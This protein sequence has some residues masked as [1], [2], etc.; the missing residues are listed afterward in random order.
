M[1]ILATWVCIDT[2]DNAS[3]FPSAKGLSSDKKIQDIYWKCLVDCLYTARVYNPDIRLAVFSNIT[4]LPAIEN[5]DLNAVFK[6]LNI[7]F[8][9][10]PFKYQTPK[11][12]YGNWRNQFYEFSIFEYI[13]NN[14]SFKPE[15]NF[16]LTDSD[17]VI[18]GSLDKLF[19]EI[20]KHELL[21]YRINYKEDHVINGLS[22]VDMK[23]AFENVDGGLIEKLPDYYAGEFYA[24]SIKVV[25]EV[26]NIF[27]KVW[28]TLLQLHE[29]KE[30]VLTEEAH[31]LSYIYYKLK[32]E[33]D[34]GNAFIKRLWTDPTRYRN[35]IPE[36]RNLV[37][38]HLPAHK[39]T[40][41]NKLFNILSNK[42]F[43]TDA[44]TTSDL[45]RILSKIF[46]IP[47]L[48]FSNKIYYAVKK[49]AKVILRK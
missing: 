20:G 28:P 12:Y 31:V 26:N 16:C 27:Q 18:T 34:L 11:G 47:N 21:S 39:R 22:R 36:D 49:T 43:S 42:S 24:S 33:N 35:V 8:H 3:Y 2:D 17:C 14:N 45:T 23:K 15:D 7:E 1:N 40:G 9:S 25:H 32:L 5:I 37:I 30:L 29:K 10:T 38:W 4:A 13:A 41:F 46:T 6:Q 48:S 44:F 19:S